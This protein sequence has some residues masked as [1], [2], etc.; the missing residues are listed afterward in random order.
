MGRLSR[1]VE[2]CSALTRWICGVRWRRDAFIPGVVFL[3]RRKLP[4]APSIGV[5][6]RD[7]FVLTG[8]TDAR[9]VL[10]G[11]LA[12]DLPGVV[13]VVADQAVRFGLP[14]CQRRGSGGSDHSQRPCVHGWTSNLRAA[15][16]R[17]PAG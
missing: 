5:A 15:M 6:V 13:G 1:K 10:G 8:L 14:L 12:G 4:D 9:G 11:L 7:G 17:R 3:A 16:H 2:A